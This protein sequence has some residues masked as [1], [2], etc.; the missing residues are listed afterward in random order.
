[1]ASMEHNGICA[2]CLKEKLLQSSHLLPKALYR[3]VIGSNQDPNPVIVTPTS[4]WQSSK[5]VEAHLLCSDCEQLF[6][7]RGEDWTL[8][9]CYRGQRRFRLQETL[10]RAAPLADFGDALVFA[11]ARIPAIDIGQ[12]VYFAASVFWRAS[13]IAG[14]HRIII[15]KISNLGGSTGRSSADTYWAKPGSPCTPLF[16]STSLVFGHPRSPR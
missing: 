10:A 8:R 9:Q 14:M 16:S 13:A 11:A 3:F 5:Q 15:W 4:A 1:M 7:R 6:H 12:L 2:L